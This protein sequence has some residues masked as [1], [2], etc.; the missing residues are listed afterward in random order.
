VAYLQ[1]I[2]TISTEGT[3]EPAVVTAARK[4][5]PRVDAVSDFKRSFQHEFVGRSA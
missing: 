2:V 3:N 4:H 1:S 5:A